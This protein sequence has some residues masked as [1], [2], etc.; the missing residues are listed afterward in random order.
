[1]NC[2]AGAVNHGKTFLPS[3]A[4]PRYFVTAIRQVN[5]TTPPGGSQTWASLSQRAQYTQ[6]IM[7]EEQAQ[8]G[9]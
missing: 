2:V 7:R 9:C 5:K 8:A 4:L 3:A 1:M 6:A